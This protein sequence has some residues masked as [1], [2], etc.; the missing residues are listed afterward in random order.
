MRWARWEIRMA[1]GI[2]L[3]RGPCQWRVVLNEC[4]ELAKDFGGTDGHKYVNAVL[5]GVAPLFRAAEVESDR[6]TDKA[7]D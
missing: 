7:R 4:I 5:S 1:L 2:G 3:S 6:A